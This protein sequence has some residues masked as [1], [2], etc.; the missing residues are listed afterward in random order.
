MELLRAL[1]QSQNLFES[2]KIDGVDQECHAA[3]FDGNSA[4]AKCWIASQAGKVS[5]RRYDLL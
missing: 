1:Y 3:Q 5:Y 2:L 4:T